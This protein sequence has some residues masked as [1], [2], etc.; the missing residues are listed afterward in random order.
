[1]D[2]KQRLTNDM[3]QAMKAR[4]TAKLSLLRMLLSAINYAQIEA[5]SN[6]QDEDIIAVLRKEAKKRREA[7]QAYQQANRPKLAAKEKQEL[8]LIEAYLPQQLDSKQIKSEI[9][10]IL[11]DKT[12][13][14]FGQAMGMVMKELKG[15]ADGNLVN[16]AVKTYLASLN[17]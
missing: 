10:R 9:D 14:N 8:S 12:G 17:Q 11:K 7:I 2:L 6:L 1:M 15:K 13:L 3:K 4:E 5:S 16:Q